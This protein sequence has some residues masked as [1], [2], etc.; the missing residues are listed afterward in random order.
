M[1]SLTALKEKN[2]TLARE[3][4]ESCRDYVE[5]NFAFN[6]LAQRYK[7]Q[8]RAFESF[9]MQKENLD[10]SNANARIEA[11]V[12]SEMQNATQLEFDF[13]KTLNNTVRED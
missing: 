9:L 8:K 7:L 6:E 13:Q 4:A 5:L 10:K 11:L 2:E 12:K 3:L 1:K